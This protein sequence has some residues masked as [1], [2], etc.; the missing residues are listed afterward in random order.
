MAI[1]SYYVSRVRN[2]EK[3]LQVIC[4]EYLKED[5]IKSG[6]VLHFKH[7][8]QK[9]GFIFALCKIGNKIYSSYQKNAEVTDLI[10]LQFNYSDNQ[11]LK[12]REQIEA[13]GEALTKPPIKT[14]A[15]KEGCSDLQGY[16]LQIEVPD[17]IDV[18]HE[19]VESVYGKGRNIKSS[20]AHTFK[21]HAN[22]ILSVSLVKMGDENWVSNGTRI[23]LALAMDTL[24]GGSEVGAV[25]QTREEM[26]EHFRKSA[27]NPKTKE[28]RSARAA[29]KRNQVYQQGQDAKVT[30]M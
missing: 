1:F 29:K 22:E 13:E 30:E 12:L 19:V 25:P 7:G 28:Q 2:S 5:G 21:F 24:F 9:G 18:L 15:G 27:T 17:D 4:G 8:F 16:Q 10:N 11:L 14:E 20:K 23:N 26:L 6:S 3:G